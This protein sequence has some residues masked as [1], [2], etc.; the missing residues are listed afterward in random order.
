VLN[1]KVGKVPFLYLGMPIGGN[2]R[3]L[4][5]WDPVVNHIKARLSGWN[6][7]F[8]Y[9]GGRLVL[10]KSV[11]TSLLVYALSFFKAPSSI[12]SSIESLLNKF[13]WVG[14]TNTGKFLGSV[15]VQFVSKRSLE[16]WGLD[17]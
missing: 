2:P 14:V 11:F 4:C 9:F 1:C 10:L 13:F 12:I 5:F 3:R 17:S 8:L 15:G 16:G 6:S 7:R